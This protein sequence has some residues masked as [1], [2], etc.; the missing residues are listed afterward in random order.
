VVS[1]ARGEIW[2]A[3]LNPTRG[4]EQAGRRPVLV[5]SDDVF[6][7]GPAGL[8]V[9]LPITPTVRRQAL[10]LRLRPPEGG[11]RVESSILCDAVR[12][13]SQERLIGRWG[14]VTDATIAAVEARLRALLGL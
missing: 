4:H 8:V 7:Q 2:L 14:F 13:V 1:P 9:V 6:N 10:H 3:D 12:S 11:L 5:I